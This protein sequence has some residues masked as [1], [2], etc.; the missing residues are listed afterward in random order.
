METSN[1][2]SLEDIQNQNCFTISWLIKNGVKKS[3]KLSKLTKTSFFSSLMNWLTPTKKTFN[4][5]NTSCFKK[6]LL[7]VNGFNE[8]MQYGGLDRELGERLFNYGVLAKQVRYS[9]AC[10][11]LDHKRS[12]ASSETWEKNNAIRLYNRKNNITFIANGISKQL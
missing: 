11:H 7:A 8:A 9:A 2:I 4:G 5:H 12:Y 3:F 10:L 1:K 6:D